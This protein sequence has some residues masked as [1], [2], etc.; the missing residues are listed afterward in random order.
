MHMADKPKLQNIISIIVKL[1]FKEYMTQI[2]HI[3]LLPSVHGKKT[4]RP[5]PS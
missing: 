4:D 2:C 3:N 5:A 1:I